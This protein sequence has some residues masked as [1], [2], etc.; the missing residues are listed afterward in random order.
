MGITI[1]HQD[2]MG[3]SEYGVGADIFI[4]PSSRI[5]D[6][7]RYEM[8]ECAPYL[9]AVGGCNVG[10]YST[11]EQALEVL[12]EIQN[13]INQLQYESV[14]FVTADALLEPAVYKMPPDRGARYGR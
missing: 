10:S 8:E 3:L 9:I 5:I 2:K 14:R 11:K 13:K 12:D 7:K 1:R 4:Y 6:G